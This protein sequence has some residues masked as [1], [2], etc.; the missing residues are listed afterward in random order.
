MNDTFDWP[1]WPALEVSDSGVI[2][3][4]QS[5]VTLGNPVGQNMESAPAP[6]VPPVDDTLVAPPVDDTL[7]APPVDDTL[8]APPVDDTLVAPPVDDHSDHDHDHLAP[9]ADAGDYIDITTW[10]TF[11]GSNHNSE[12]DELV[13]GTR[14]SPPKRW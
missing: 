10:G 6:V 13:G 1:Q 5:M 2:E 3:Y 14:P 7:V 11:H 12:H 4:Y 9:P 8:V